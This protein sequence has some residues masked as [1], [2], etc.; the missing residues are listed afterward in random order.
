MADETEE[1]L[2]D[3]YLKYQNELGL[4]DYRILWEACD[5]LYKEV[6]MHFLN[7]SKLKNALTNPNLATIRRIHAQL[8]TNESTAKCVPEFLMERYRRRR[9]SWLL[10]IIAAIHEPIPAPYGK[11]DVA[12]LG[13][14]CHL[15]AK[16]K[17]VCFS[18]FIV[19]MES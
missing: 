13:L 9:G 17:K 3:Y 5:G 15:P 19:V 4:K 2:Q 11:V 14:S 1:L 10:L 18:F 12:F 16:I 8:Q 7:L 6:E